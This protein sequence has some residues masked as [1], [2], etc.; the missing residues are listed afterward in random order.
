MAL[1]TANLFLV[2]CPTAAVQKAIA[3][4]DNHQVPIVCTPCTYFR[5]CATASFA[6]KAMPVMVVESL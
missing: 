6:N 5:D 2:I 1:A 4:G 3:S